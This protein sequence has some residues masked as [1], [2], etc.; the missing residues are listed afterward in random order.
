MIREEYIVEELL[1]IC[2]P[3]MKYI[4]EHHDPY[5]KV[6]IDM[7]GVRVMGTELSIPRGER[8]PEN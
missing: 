1:K 4:D 2:E 8:Q 3:I 5:T 7:D 6:V